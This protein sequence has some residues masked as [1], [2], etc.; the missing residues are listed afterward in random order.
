MKGK[1]ILLY[2]HH[3][4]AYVIVCVWSNQWE[5]KREDVSDRKK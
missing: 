2:E 1:F 5:R 3:Y 4:E